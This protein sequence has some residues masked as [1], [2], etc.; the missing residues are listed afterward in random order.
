[1]NKPLIEL[2]GEALEGLM[3]RMGDAKE[4]SLA[5][6]KEDNELLLSALSTLAHLQERLASK[7]ITLNKLRKLLGIAQASEKLKHLLPKQEED[8][9][10]DPELDEAAR[11]LRKKK[12]RAEKR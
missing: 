6:S 11:A 1:M 5:L 7:D 8:K 4:Y 12:S 3:Q 2:D 9:T 10:T